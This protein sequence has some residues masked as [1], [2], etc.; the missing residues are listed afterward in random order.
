M[1][2]NLAR[3]F[4]NNKA[5]LLQQIDTGFSSLQQVAL[6]LKESRRR[7]FVQKIFQN[8]EEYC[9]KKYAPTLPKLHLC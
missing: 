4:Y 5:L 6:L 9:G 2:H 1:L 7:V 3:L 8:A